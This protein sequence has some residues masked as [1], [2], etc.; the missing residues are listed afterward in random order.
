MSR[1][2]VSTFFAGIDTANT[3]AAQK[4]PEA[5]T[6][7][8]VIVYDADTG[9]EVLSTTKNIAF[10]RGTSTLG[11]PLIS[12][13]IPV[14]G[15]TSAT[16][17]PY[18]APVNKEMTLTVN[19]VPTVGKTCIFRVT[20]HDNLSIIPNQV[21]QT[22]VA[23]T[24]D[25][26]NTATTTTWAA[27]IAAQ[28]NLQTAD[29]GGR[30]FVDVTS[31][32][33]VVTFVGQ[34]IITQSS[35]NG[36]DRPET[37]NFELGAPED[38]GYGSYT[39]AVTVALESGQGDASKTAWLEEQHMGRLGF[40]DRRMWN[41]TKKYPSQVQAGGTYDVLVITADKE[42]EGDMQGTRKYP[43]GVTIA[44]ES[45]T[46]ALILVDLARV[47]IVPETVAA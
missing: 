21:K 19:T 44:G 24:A 8:Q 4:D 31:S 2:H 41:D 13:I 32:T 34:T 9:I 5:L 46:L 36:I 38:A 29:L 6:D 37:L 23:V 27:A 45:D 3:T 43:I 39:K 12:G 30:I 16:L 15:I 7:R 17:N 20:Y 10:A 47:G 26:V 14:A 28:F 11:E 1:N 33:N 40:S 25:A 35:Y 18:N 42:A 22:I